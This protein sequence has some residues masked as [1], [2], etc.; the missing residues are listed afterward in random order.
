MS[1]RVLA[2]TTLASGG[3]AALAQ[4]LAIVG[5]L[6]ADAKAQL[7]ARYER[8]ATI[9]GDPATFFTIVDYPD[10]AAVEKV[11]H[12]PDYLALG[13]VRKAAFARYDISIMHPMDV[14]E[15]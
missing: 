6:M 8:H 2:E 15:P 13:A 9:A 7:V 11:F 12:H 4:Y 1:I 10:R 5:P 14:S 3:D